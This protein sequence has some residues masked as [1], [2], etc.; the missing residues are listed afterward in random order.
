M[1][2]AEPLLLADG[3]AI[4]EWKAVTR[5]RHGDDTVSRAGISLLRL[6]DAGLVVEQ[7]DYWAEAAGEH[8]PFQRA[9]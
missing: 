2:F 7:R 6:D 4:V 8:A 9:G 1:T 3:G 5:A